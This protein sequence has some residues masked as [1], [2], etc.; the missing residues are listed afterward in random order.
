MKTIYDSGTPGEALLR[1]VSTL[2]DLSGTGVFPVVLP[3]SLA[4]DRDALREDLQT[5]A[6][7]CMAV[8]SAQAQSL[9]E[10]SDAP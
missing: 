4:F 9:K 10:Q 1:G 7:D 3:S 8:L 2:F 5:L 6:G